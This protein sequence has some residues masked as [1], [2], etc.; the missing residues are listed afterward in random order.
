MVSRARRSLLSGGQQG[1]C[2]RVQ[3]DSRKIPDTN[4]QGAG[5]TPHET[6]APSPWTWRIP[7]TPQ[8]V[9][10]TRHEQMS[11][12][13]QALCLAKLCAHTKPPPGGLIY[14]FKGIQVIGPCP[15]HFMGHTTTRR[16]PICSTPIRAAEVSKVLGKNP[17]RESKRLV[18]ILC[19]RHHQAH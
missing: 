13:D 14:P 15:F 7:N 4:T 1:P 12:I 17:L 5:A 19:A 16:G 10:T 3:I 18:S 9:Y 11:S 2:T 8:G 6:S